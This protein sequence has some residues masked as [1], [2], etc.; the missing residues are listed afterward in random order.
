MHLQFPFYL[1]ATYCKDITVAMPLDNSSK[2]SGTIKTL[3]RKQ[4]SPNQRFG[5][6]A[7]TL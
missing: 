4:L 5:I 2:L 3:K 1:M 6:S 7:C